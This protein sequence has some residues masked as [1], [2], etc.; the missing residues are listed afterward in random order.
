MTTD[1]RKRGLRAAVDVKVRGIIGDGDKR[2]LSQVQEVELLW[3]IIDAL[4]DECAA[5]D[6]A[7]ATEVRYILKHNAP[8]DMPAMLVL[9]LERL[10]RGDLHCHICGKPKGQPPERCPGHYESR[11]TCCRKHQDLGYDDGGFCAG[12]FR[13]AE[14][15]NA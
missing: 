4:V 10:E 2:V 8:K 7:L 15:E 14:S 13:P 6:S 12:K 9:A 1:E 3:S 11:P 5:R